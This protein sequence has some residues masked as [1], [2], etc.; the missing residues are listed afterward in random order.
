M[1]RCHLLG[2]TDSSLRNSA[3]ISGLSVLIITELIEGI[4]N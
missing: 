1:C 3:E 2:L 4:R